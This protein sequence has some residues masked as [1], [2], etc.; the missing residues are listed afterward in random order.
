V[1]SFKYL[2]FCC[3]HACY[4][5][6]SALML[7]VGRQEG[8]L[9]CKKT[10]WWVAGV[11][12]CLDRGADLHMAQLMPLPLTVS[13]FSKIQTGFTFLVPAHP[14][15]TTYVQV[16][17]DI[18]PLNGC[19][20]TCMLCYHLMHLYFQNCIIV[21]CYITPMSTCHLSPNVFLW[22]EWS[23]RLEWNMISAGSPKTIVRTEV[24]L[25]I[26]FILCVWYGSHGNVFKCVAC[27]LTVLYRMKSLL[28]AGCI[29]LSLD[30]RELTSNR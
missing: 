4:S 19:M 24:M 1:L 3:L 14:G 28:T 21:T 27:R 26:T 23:M 25:L 15:R 30:Q 2:F 18:G 8:N 11:V 5:A 13:C 22:N 9:A 20:C 16:V 17:L 6:F 10:E 29:D 7:L 12:I